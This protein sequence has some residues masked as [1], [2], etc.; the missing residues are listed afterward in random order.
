RSAPLIAQRIE[1][2]SSDD[3]S[4]VRCAFLNLLGI[5]PNDAEMKASM[6]AL[7]AWQSRSSGTEITP[8]ARFIW[9]L[10]NHNDFVTLR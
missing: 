9:V 8:R 7:S 3:E 5:D 6:Q 1:E 4:F 10:M 2:V